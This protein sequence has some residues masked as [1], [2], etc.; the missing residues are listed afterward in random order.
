MNNNIISVLGEIVH[1]H[2]G[3]YKT[4]QSGSI[5]ES[6]REKYLSK[7]EYSMLG[8]NADDNYIVDTGL[9]DGCNYTWITY[10]SKNSLDSTS[11]GR[12]HTIYVPCNFDTV[13]EI[14]TL[15]KFPFADM[16]ESQAIV[17]GDVK[18]EDNHRKEKIYQQV[19]QNV[20]D[21]PF[22]NRELL[23]CMIC[24][25]LKQSSLGAKKIL[26]I[27][28]PEEIEDY[29]KYCLS[30]V[31]MILSAIPVGLRTRLRFA[32]NAS[33][34]WEFKYH[35]LFIKQE[36][37]SRITGRQKSVCLWEDSIPGYLLNHG[38]NPSLTKLI[39]DCVDMPQN[40]G[41]HSQ[42]NMCREEMQKK[43]RNKIDALKFKDYVEYAERINPVQL[44]DWKRE[45]LKDFSIEKIQ[46]I[47]DKVFEK[48]PQQYNEF[49]QD[50]MNQI[51]EYRKQEISIGTYI[52]LLKEQNS[53]LKVPTILFENYA[54]E[55][56]QEL[57]ENLSL[58]KIN[59]IIQKIKVYFGDNF[60]KDFIIKISEKI[61]SLFSNTI[62][63]DETILSQKNYSELYKLL[64]QLYT[65]YPED[66]EQRNDEKI[67][68]SFY[69]TY[70][71]G[72]KIISD[73]E[74]GRIK[75]ENIRDEDIKSINFYVDDNS[76]KYIKNLISKYIKEHDE[77]F[78]FMPKENKKI[79]NIYDLLQWQKVTLDEVKFWYLGW[80]ESIKR[81]KRK[82]MIQEYTNI[83]ESYFYVCKNEQNQIKEKDID[84]FR[85]QI[86]ERN[87]NDF[88]LSEYTLGAFLSAVEYIEENSIEQVFETLLLKEFYIKEFKEFDNASQIPILITKGMRL[89]EIYKQVKYYQL[90]SDQDTVEFIY[91]SKEKK[92][93]RSN[94]KIA[95]YT[96]Q[97]MIEVSSYQIVQMDKSQDISFDSKTKQDIV[98]LWCFFKR[99]ELLDE[100]IL[101]CIQELS[102]DNQI[103][104]MNDILQAFTDMDNKTI[105][106]KKKRK[107]ITIIVYIIILLISFG[108]GILANIVIT[109]LFDSK[110]AS[111][112][113]IRTEGT[114]NIIENYMLE[115]FLSNYDV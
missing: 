82:K 10:F 46:S 14:Q 110:S 107:I 19:Y 32:T 94:L 89:T 71:I 95:L 20:I 92:I 43:S 65:Y 40:I 51:G 36:Q 52:S 5:S 64:K 79:D 83:F 44:D 3:E 8:N 114:R 24:Y 54:L 58:D 90:L 77:A 47:C 80:R 30:I 91:I 42:I 68:L 99:A 75:K 26:Y 41:L 62:F 15:L 101:S 88:S 70:Y 85:I 76:R 63:E 66:I 84:K 111:V 55:L 25:L 1:D 67:L 109:N 4:L 59:E 73:Y 9:C 23:Y 69:G 12:S 106:K 27:M 61:K 98:K 104:Q 56:E 35:I 2:Y 16:Q 102:D 11:S 50:I 6:D 105:A 49:C 38:L 48:Y 7:K 78:Q 108:L 39:K 53:M 37:F 93:V 86:I 60:L 22:V 45:I 113:L 28:V 97:M 29:Q 112:N 33:E 21:E 17:S 31:A 72:K 103:V 115:E 18:L 57:F 87:Q 81:L 100:E 74:N 96:I 34:N 13:Y